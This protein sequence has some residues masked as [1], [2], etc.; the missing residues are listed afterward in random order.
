MF[1]SP[2]HWA[3]NQLPEAWVSVKLMVELPA[4]PPARLIDASMVLSETIFPD[5]TPIFE[6]CWKRSPDE[7]PNRT[8]P[9]NVTFSQPV[10]VE[11]N[12]PA[13]F[14][15]N[16]DGV[17]VVGKLLLTHPVSNASPVAEITIDILFILKTL[18]IKED[19]YENKYIFKYAYTI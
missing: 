2:E 12:A 15:S 7:C 9:S 3:L 19:N 17:P 5:S 4:E 1:T 6:P 8:S 13:H 16:F 11:G 10:L 18:I 14:P